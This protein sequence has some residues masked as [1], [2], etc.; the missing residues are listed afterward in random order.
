MELTKRHWNDHKTIPDLQKG[1]FSTAEIHLLRDLLCQWAKKHQL[2]SEELIDLCSDTRSR[3]STKVWCSVAKHFPRRSVQSLHNVS[4]RVFNPNNYKG[5][6]AH[7]EEQELVHFVKHNGH[8]WKA[9]GEILGRTALNV[10]DK[11]KQM[12]GDK[13]DCRKKG[14]W[15]SG[16]IVALIRLVQQNSAV[17]SIPSEVLT[18]CEGLKDEEEVFAHIGS[19]IQESPELS[20]V[21]ELNWS[22]ISQL[23]VT[24]SAVDCRLKWNRC[25]LGKINSADSFTYEEDL[26]LI[27][28]IEEQGAEDMSEI[29]W[30]RLETG[31]SAQQNKNR[32]RTLFNV[33]CG[34]LKLTL[35][36]VLRQLKHAYTV[37]EEP[38]DSIVDF[39]Q[40]H[41][42]IHK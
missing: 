37:Y 36:E 23:L 10:K 9:I 27:Q 7:W 11:W 15:S 29:R 40:K 6:W 42:L 20:S 18:A 14:P 3:N 12:G 13:H 33:T 4:R 30:E 39:Y 1:P 24:R 17:Q 41:Y 2:T 32:F 22:I 8:K 31:R 34:R 16:E 26:K 19:R 38:E 35:E 21:K 5:G 25:V 28:G